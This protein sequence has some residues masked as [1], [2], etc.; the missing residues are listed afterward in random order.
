MCGNIRLGRVAGIGIA[1]HYS[2]FLITLLHE[3]AHA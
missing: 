1:L 3:L 2:W